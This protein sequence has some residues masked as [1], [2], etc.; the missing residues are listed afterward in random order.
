MKYVEAGGI[1]VSAIGLGTWQF[2]SPDWGYGNEWA[3]IV[4]PAP[5][6]RALEQPEENLA[7]FALTSAELEH[8]TAASAAYAR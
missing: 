2:A 6:R 4:A 8:L 3:A 5:V 7:D 1:R